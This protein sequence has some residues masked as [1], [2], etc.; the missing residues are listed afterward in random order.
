[1]S[2]NKSNDDRS[3]YTPSDETTGELTQFQRNLF[4]H[5]KLMTARDMELEQRYH[6]QRLETLARTVAGTGVVCG[7]AT[8]V[9]QSDSGDLNVSVA[10]GVGLDA[11]GRPVVVADAD[12]AT[13][14]SWES[15][16]LA[17]PEGVADPSGVSIFLTYDDCRTEKVPI[18]GS[19]DACSQSC[20]YNRIIEFYD[21]S[22]RRGPPAGPKPVPDIDFPA[23]SVFEDTNGH[24]KTDRGLFTVAEEYVSETTVGVERPCDDTGADRLFLGYF[25]PTGDGNEWSLVDDEVAPHRV[26]TND[27]LYS[28]IARHTSDFANPHQV[29]LRGQSGT[30]NSAALFTQETDDL[31]TIRA[32]DTIEVAWN[33]DANVVD[34]E[35]GEWLTDLKADVEQLRSDH[36]T[37][38]NNHEAL[39]EEHNTLLN[40]HESLQQDHGELVE[41][42]DLLERYVMD[43][44]LKYKYRLFD[45]LATWYAGSPLGEKAEGITEVVEEAIKHR[46]YR[47][48]AAF[49][50]I[51]RKVYR[52]FETELPTLLDEHGGIEVDD[53]V[54]LNVKESLARLETLLEEKESILEIALAQDEV[55]EAIEVLDHQALEHAAEIRPREAEV[56]V[57]EEI[58]FEIEDSSEES[59]TVSAE[60][61][62]GDG[63][64]ATG[65]ETTHS[66]D[67]QG[68]YDVSLTAAAQTGATSTDTVTVTVLE[69]EEE[70]LETY[71]VPKS[72]ELNQ[73]PKLPV[74]PTT[75][76]AEG[77]HLL[78]SVPQDAGLDH[79]L[80]EAEPGD[81][82]AA[83]LGTNGIYVDIYLE[84]EENP[85]GT[86]NPD[87]HQLHLLYLGEVDDTEVFVVPQPNA[88]WVFGPEPQTYRIEYR[89]TTD[90]AAIDEPSEEV[91]RSREIDWVHRELQLDDGYETIPQ[92]ET[93]ISGVV[94]FAPDSNL[95]L[96]LLAPEGHYEFEASTQVTEDRTFSIDLDTSDVPAV[97][98]EITVYD[99]EAEEIYEFTATI[100][101]PSDPSTF[102]E[103]SGIGDVYAEALYDIGITSRTALAEANEE[104]L[105][106]QLEV[107]RDEVSSWIDQAR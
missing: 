77:D 46:V 60:W 107:S 65:M 98:V 103:I 84:D 49:I 21:I 83:D 104:E 30:D 100:E 50:E 92:G 78:F 26:Y 87:I 7:L 80:A 45:D 95:Q 2:K 90:N 68:S 86:N 89:V 9:E 12:E 6:A 91:H 19:E 88:H 37:L 11:A 54:E 59:T 105:A 29:S 28:G 35:R 47:D 74:T 17:D 41:R 44:T 96:D 3:N 51:I 57:G 62:F 38:A 40:D 23:E 32:D 43:K 33:S 69:I 14:T 70:P 101:E 64:T 10:S 82:V 79:A 55:C 52:D 97:D 99:L 76:I 13:F 102:D 61:D 31:V 56:E 27:M 63:N 71:T 94:T 5:G 25:E 24:S 15:A 75:D 20:T 106:N 48:H 16:A 42:V 67:A 22:L 34:L 39:E 85:T 73:F 81:E 58:T 72:R 66:F 53:D 1:M 36:D 18:G 4:F 8:A 93:T